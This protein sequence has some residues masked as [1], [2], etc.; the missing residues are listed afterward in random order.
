MIRVAAFS[1]R[2]FVQCAQTLEARS[3]VW[4]WGYMQVDIRDAYARSNRERILRN[5]TLEE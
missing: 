5:E 1:R 4:T 3:R 2:P